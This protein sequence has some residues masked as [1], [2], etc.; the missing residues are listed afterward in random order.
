MSIR[1]C[2]S[3][4]LLPRA[5][6]KLN[7]RILPRG[8]LSPDTDTGAEA[9]RKIRAVMVLAMMYCESMQIVVGTYGGERR[10]EMERMQVNV[11]ETAQNRV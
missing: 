5:W 4:A 2:V 6:D 11:C 10:T 3:A 8:K 7:R 1:I 9:V